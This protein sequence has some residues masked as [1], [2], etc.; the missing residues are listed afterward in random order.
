MYKNNTYILKICGRG[1]NHRI[2]VCLSVPQDQVRE[3]QREKAET[4]MKFN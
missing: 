2:G 4:E 1:G 3:E